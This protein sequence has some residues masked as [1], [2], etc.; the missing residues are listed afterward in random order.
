MT[1][2]C[3]CLVDNFSEEI[4]GCRLS[5][6]TKALFPWAVQFTQD[7]KGACSVRVCMY[8]FLYISVLS[9]LQPFSFEEGHR[10]RGHHQWEWGADEVRAVIILRH[11]WVL[12]PALMSSTQVKYSSKLVK[13]IN[14][15]S[16]TNAPL[17]LYHQNSVCKIV[18]KPNNP[19]AS[20]E[21]Q[22][23]IFKYNSCWNCWKLNSD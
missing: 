14:V 13:Y 1:L 22:F 21:T 17:A 2:L 5:A 23:Q 11:K 4:P 12:Q 7:R 8:L 19:Y 6:S 16:K 15:P 20:S 18:I 3:F 9:I 10:S